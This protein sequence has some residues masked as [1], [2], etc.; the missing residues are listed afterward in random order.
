[1]VFKAILIFVIVAILMEDGTSIRKTEQEEK[2]DKELAELV[3]KTLAEEAEKKEEEEKKKKQLDPVKKKDEI[4]K[5]DETKKKDEKEEKNRTQDKT[6]E[7]DVKGKDRDEACPPLNFTCPTVEPC[8]PCPEVKECPE[9]K[10]CSPCKKCGICPPVKPCPVYNHTVCQCPEEDVGMT[11]PVALAVGASAGVLLTGVAA[12][13]G[14]IIR[15]FSPIESGFLF[16]ATII[17]VWYLSSQYPETAR[18]LGGRAAALLRE[19]ATALSHRVVEALQRHNG[20]V[21]F[22]VLSLFLLPMF[23]F[24][25]SKSLH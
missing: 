18:E 25:V 9:I 22:P 19:A 6:G 20:Q 24:H 21:G 15:Y 12:V 8:D 2:E 4:Q 13:L 3:N 10:E 1:M 23:E 5:K 11:V 7:E 16:L 17:I 14:L